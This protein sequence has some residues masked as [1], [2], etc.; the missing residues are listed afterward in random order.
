MELDL[1]TGLQSPRALETV[2]KYHSTCY[3]YQTTWNRPSVHFFLQMLELEPGS[4]AIL[5]R[6]SLLLHRVGC[7][8]VAMRM[9]RA[10]RDHSRSEHERLIY[11]GWML[12]D[13][14]RRA[15]AFE[16]AQVG[17]TAL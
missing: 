15:E 9:L 13:T 14:G 2:G 12:F 6:Q 16:K 17:S 5:F 7:S 11:E 10:A 1:C 8:D 4:S 3:D